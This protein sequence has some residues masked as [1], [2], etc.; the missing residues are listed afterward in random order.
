MIEEAQDISSILKSGKLEAPAK[1]V[2]EQVVGPT[3]GQAAV[4][5][6][7][8]S[9]AIAFAVIFILMVVYYNTGGWVANIALILN[10]LFTVGVLSAMGA[11]LTCSGY[12]RSGAYHRYRSRHQRTDIRTYQGR[13]HQGARVISKL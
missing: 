3:L 7:I 9:F 8:L 12:R 13:A 2:Q 1:I 5:G 11:T 10:L 4:K 6:G